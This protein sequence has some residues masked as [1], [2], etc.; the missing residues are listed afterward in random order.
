[1]ARIHDHHRSRGSATGRIEKTFVRSGFH[2][3]P[4]DPSRIGI[5]YRLNL[6]PYNHAA[7]ADVNEV[8]V[9]HNEVIRFSAGRA[10]TSDI[11]RSLD[12]GRAQILNDRQRHTGLLGGRQKFGRPKK[13][14]T[15]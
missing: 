7:K 5:T 10:R 1:M 9:L 4:F 14:Q 2:N 12:L 3:Q 11:E 6:M 13:C 8:K 15:Q